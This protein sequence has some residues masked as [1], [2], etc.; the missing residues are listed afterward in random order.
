MHEVKKH[1]ATLRENSKEAVEVNVV[2]FHDIQDDPLRIDIRKWERKPDGTRGQMF[3]NG[4]CLSFEEAAELRA[5]LN[6]CKALDDWD[7]ER[8]P[9]PFK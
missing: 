5:V 3:R 6:D 2:L 7:A 9:L 1:L 4:V 8:N